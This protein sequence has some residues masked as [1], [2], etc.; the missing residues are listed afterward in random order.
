M[1]ECSFCKKDSNQ[2]DK[3]IAGDGVFICNE[4]IDICN[5]TIHP[6]PAISISTDPIFDIIEQNM[7]CAILQHYD[8]RIL[9]QMKNW[10][11]ENIEESWIRVYKEPDRNTSTYKIYFNSE[12]DLIAFKL[13]WI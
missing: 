10:I 4:C 3:L 13:R 6:N 7:Y 11:K 1:Q 12:S 5:D 8:E 2:V 9:S